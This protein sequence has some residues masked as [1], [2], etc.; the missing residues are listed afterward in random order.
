M[1]GAVAQ[2][3]R[4]LIGERVKSGLANARTNG[5]LLGPPPYACYRM[6]NVAH[7]EWRALR[8]AK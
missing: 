1:I 3:E 5:K 4:S 7:I 8:M 2:F 6:R